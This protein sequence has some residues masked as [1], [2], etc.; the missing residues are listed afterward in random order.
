M[1]SVELE[2]YLDNIKKEI[3]KLRKDF[4]EIKIVFDQLPE[5]AEKDRE[6][7]TS[8]LAQIKN[9]VE[10]LKILISNLELAININF[11]NMKT[12][13]EDG[14]KSTL[15]LSLN[16]YFEQELPK[17]LYVVQKVIAKN[18]LRAFNENFKSLFES[19]TKELNS[20]KNENEGLNKKINALLYLLSKNNE[21]KLR[22]FLLTTDKKELKRKELEKIFGK[23]VVSKVLNELNGKIDVKIT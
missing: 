21:D 8:Y 22:V 13:L 6:V 23:E 15:I 9:V 20:I 4:K 7:L 18:Q 1:D 19:I 11:K 14:M 12:E 16:Q 2:A 3:E 17:M 5:M 10:D